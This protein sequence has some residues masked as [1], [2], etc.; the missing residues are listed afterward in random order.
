MDVWS[1]PL[2]T[3]TAAG[4]GCEVQQT[5][6][7]GE[8]EAKLGSGLPYDLVVID[9]VLGDGRTSGPE[10]LARTR[11]LDADVPVVAVAE[12]G[13]VE[14]AAKAI[15]GERPTSWSA[16]A[17]SHDG[18]RRSSARSGTSSP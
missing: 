10:I 11:M 1:I 7:A 2:T 18:S 9:Y 4:E 15:G 12:K 8:L 17:A 13:D 16:G 14:I 3:R 5:S 6:T